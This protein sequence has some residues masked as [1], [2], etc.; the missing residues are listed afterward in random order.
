M[1]ASKSTRRQL[2]QMLSDRIQV[3][4]RTHLEHQPAKVVCQI[5]DNKIAIVLEDAVTRPVQFLV[6][7]GK[8]ELAQ[9]M[10]SNIHKALEPQL[11][12]LIEQV[13]S[14][15]VVDL[16]SDAKLES[17]RTGAI[18]VL[19]AAPQFEDQNQSRP[20]SPSADGVG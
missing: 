3:R 6:E 10:R 19:A 20:E 1:E 16:L 11:K 8:S 2:E 13:V 4:Y 15:A 9:K 14:I 5:F 17:G 7:Q 12:E 18:A